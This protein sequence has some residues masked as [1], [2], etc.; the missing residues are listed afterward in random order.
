MTDMTTRRDEPQ[1][2]DAGIEELLQQV[3]ARAEPSVEVERE[4]FAAAHAEWRSLVEERQRKRRFMVSGMAAGFALIVLVATF[5]LQLT[6]TPA[7]PIATLLR[8]EGG[9]AIDGERGALRTGTAGGAIVAGE[10]LTTDRTG[11]VALDIGPGVSLRLDRETVVRFAAN[12]RVTLEA[13]TVYVDSPPSDAA[14]PLTIESRAGSIR[15]VGTQYLVRD[16]RPEVEI[17][18]REGRILVTNSAGT[19]AGEAGEQLRVTESGQITRA[20]IAATDETWTWAESMAPTFDINE[21]SLAS[22]LAWVARET[23]RELVYQSPEARVAATGI[24]LHGSI[25]GL[26]LDTALA[27]VLSTTQLRQYSA[28]ADRIGIM[29]TAAV[30]E[31]ERTAGD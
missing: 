14:V 2:D 28:G 25:R 9:L 20:R 13:G 22:F 26:D 15:H 3:G 27:A 10:R 17:S 12:D 16:A 31:R 23:G 8:V 1:V 24:K 4:V 29:L 21:R 7:H 30:G 6:V 11:R 5:G 18:V 19:S